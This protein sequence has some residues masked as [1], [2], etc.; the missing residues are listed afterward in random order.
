MSIYKKPGVQST[1]NVS[2]LLAV[3]PGGIRVAY[4]VG[5]GATT[6]NTTQVVTRAVG[7][8]DTLDPSASSI[9]RAYPLSLYP[10]FSSS[11]YSLFNG[12]IKW[13]VTSD[14][15]AVPAYN[16]DYYIDYVYDKVDA[17]Y[18]PKEF[19][20]MA[21]VIT[22]YGTA[23][24]GNSL[25]IGAQLVFENGASIVGTVQ[26][27]STGNEYVDFKTALAKL[28]LV[29]DAEVIVPLYANSVFS[30]TELKS[31]IVRM[32]SKP[33]RKER[34]GLVSLDETLE[35]I[36][37][38]S[39]E[40][41][42]EG[43]AS[44]RMALIYPGKINKILDEGE[45]ILDGT[46]LAAAIAGLM[47]S[48]AYD[49]AEPITFKDLFGIVDVSINILN[50]SKNQLATSGILIVDKRGA[51]PYVRHGLTTDMTTIAGQEISITTSIDTVV[52][53]LRDTLEG[54]FIGKKFIATLPS[55]VAMSTQT[56][57][58]QQITDNMIT[59][60]TNLNVTRDTT[61]PRQ[62]NIKVNVMPMFPCNWIEIDMT[63][64]PSA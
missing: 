37:L 13:D 27:K 57:L 25:S 54:V 29:E 4:L 61:D 50:T 55:Q 34:V 12:N 40:L 3:T 53:G 16:D 41:L 1:V 24:T 38:S 31:H 7:T 28:E 11:L 10:D 59:A 17:D 42:A 15:T 62:V 52:K 9:T 51:T 58:L 19:T 36:S 44:K 8:V 45:V 5:T 32:S 48:A 46:Y 33:E 47:T 18:E 35:S 22:E 21:S 60:Y 26:I 14:P 23:A 39:W 43:L 49:S 63:L 6:K 30:A 64:I 56:Y 2:P 20:D